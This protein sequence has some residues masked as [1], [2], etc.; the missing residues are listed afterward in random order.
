[1][2]KNDAP[3][4]ILLAICPVWSIEMPPFGMAS[5]S[6]HLRANGINVEVLDFN[7]DIFSDV[8][9]QMKRLWE[10]SCAERWDDHF[11]FK[12]ILPSFDNYIDRC[13]KK[14]L[15][16]PCNLV[17]FSVYAPNRFFSIEVMK[18]L[19][20]AD[21]AKTVIAGGRGVATS[22][23]R[24]IFPASSVDYFFLGEGEEPLVS[25]LDRLK[26]G[27]AFQ[28]LKG[29][30]S[31]DDRMREEPPYITDD[32]NKISLPDYSEFAINQY[33]EKALPIS[34]SR[35]CISRCAFCDD[36]RLAGRHRSTAAEAVIDKIEYYRERYG[37]RHFY[38]NDPAI[39]GD[40][41][42]LE[43]LCDLMIARDLGITWIALAMPMSQMRASLFQKMRRAGCITLNYG[44][45]SGSDKV[46]R[47]MGKSFAI[48]EAERVLKETRE[49]GINTQLNFI[50]G[51][52]GETGEDF[53]RT[54]FFIKRNRKY[55]CGITSLNTCNALL[56]SELSLNA[57]KYG[58]IFPEEPLLRDS[59]WHAGYDNNYE[60]RKRRA[61]KALAL[62][63]RLNLSIFVSNI[64]AKE[65]RRG[66]SKTHIKTRI[67]LW[68]LYKRV[69]LSISRWY[70]NLSRSVRADIDTI[71][72]LSGVVSPVGPRIAEIDLTDA[73]ANSCIGCWC[74]SPLLREET[75]GDTGRRRLS[76]E[77]AKAL[78]RE[79]HNLK[80]EAI[81]LSG[82]GEPFA[83]PDI[84]SVIEDIKKKGM[85]CD[86]VTSLYGV[87]EEIVEKL[88]KLKVDNLTVSL[89]AATSKTHAKTHPGNN[90]ENDFH[91]TVDILQ[92]LKEIKER[93]STSVPRV[94]LYYV[95]CNLNH[96]EIE[97]M[98]ELAVKL[99]ADSMEFSPIDIIPGK[100]EG[101]LFNAEEQ[102]EVLRDLE[103]LKM[104]IK[105]LD[106]KNESGDIDIYMDT[107]SIPSGFSYKFNGPEDVEFICPV[108][109]RRIYFDKDVERGLFSFHF[110]KLQCK[111]CHRSMDCD[112]IK[113]NFALPLK[114][115]K[116]L[117]FDSFCR[118]MKGEAA[119]TGEYDADIL[120]E[121]PCYAGWAYSRIL[122]SGDVI[123][124]C[125][126]HLAPVGNIN[127]DMFS[128]IWN[129]SLQK[130]FRA[131]VK[132]DAGYFS[133]IDCRRGCDNLAMNLD[134][135]ARLGAMDLLQRMHA[136]FRGFL[137]RFKRL[138]R[139][140]PEK[141][142]TRRFLIISLLFSLEV[143]AGLYL[144][145]L[146]LFLKRRVFPEG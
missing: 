8:H 114:F 119:L 53:S 84:L 120:K 29:I 142:K 102:A 61:R 93:R 133:K 95:I 115:I 122:P 90:K 10:R 56:G 106:G 125:K 49:A 79:L 91:R 75:S 131:G 17:G 136:K 25:Y 67:Y 70:V 63:K 24:D 3:P 135:H 71:G 35:G 51:F 73:C 124:C 46:L 7:M 97:S 57:H 19:K 45:E 108:G 58:I 36:W 101:L 144:L 130:E 94:K 59:H 16:Y 4:D 78:V 141:N 139:R 26:N 62:I 121:V 128:N 146:R 116:V 41:V 42:R 28:D 47:L 143:V 21:P 14:I 12:N 30:I 105:R 34:M 113:N 118:R 6:S 134:M 31:F 66:L 1:M 82:S 92:R 54:I 50:I 5:I 40:T 33:K 104:R 20:K 81:Q 23:E 140:S 77:S 109:E 13:V 60:E 138:P 137:Y 111:A 87:T 100:T 107:A 98:F 85:R 39:N 55:I 15:A 72:F 69:A 43:R 27:G 65:G 44:V 112:V 127:R 89:W 37:I 96:D 117:G 22:R 32:L 2:M 99:G 64:A 88:V 132:S 103:K 86:V 18:R 11:F 110:S 68:Y 52:P 48:K 9:D 126:A 129:S 74:H 80:T 76:P 83:H 38:F 145:F 123:P